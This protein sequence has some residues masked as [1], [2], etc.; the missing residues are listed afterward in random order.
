MDHA[1]LH[2]YTR[3]YTKRRSRR[4]RDKRRKSERRKKCW[5]DN[6]KTEDQGKQ[7]NQ[8]PGSGRVGQSY[9][10]QQRWM[11]PGDVTSGHH[12]RAREQG[13]APNTVSWWT[14][15]RLILIPCGTFPWQPSRHLRTR[16]DD[17]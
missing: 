5:R 7:S 11:Q 12:R 3:I 15:R 16:E 4:K 9:E 17:H 1:Y 14:W 8:F 6:S 2:P 10:T 13:P